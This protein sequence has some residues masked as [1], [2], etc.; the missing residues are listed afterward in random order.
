MFN[1]FWKITILSR[2]NI[3]NVWLDNAQYIFL[4]DWPIDFNIANQK[5]FFCNNHI[6]EIRSVQDKPTLL[7]I[8]WYWH[9]I[10]TQIPIDWTR[11]LKLKYDSL[12]Q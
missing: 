6:V 11:I 8:E 3:Q 4:E 10:C 9:F 5:I 12:T 2:K 7:M 1:S